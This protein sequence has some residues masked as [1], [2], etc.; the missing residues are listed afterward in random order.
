M[1]Y[2]IREM[3]QKKRCSLAETDYA[4]SISEMLDFR[5]FSGDFYQMR[6]KKLLFK[7]CVTVMDYEQVIAAFPPFESVQYKSCWKLPY[8]TNQLEQFANMCK[9]KEPVAVEGG[10]CLF[11][12]N[13]VLITVLLK[14]GEEQFFDFA[15]GKS[16]RA[17]APIVKLSDYL[18]QKGEQVE[19]LTFQQIKTG[20]T[21][22]EYMNLRYPFEIAKAAGASLVIPIPDMSYRK[23]LMAVLEYIPQA[24]REQALADFDAISEKIKSYYLESI[25]ALQ[26]QFQIPQFCCVHG[27]SEKELAIWY[28]KRTPYIEKKRILRTNKSEMLESI[29]DYISM[30]ALPY[31]LWNIPNILEV[32]TVEETD[33]FHKCKQAHKGIIKMSGIFYPELL[34]HDNAHTFYETFHQWKAY[35]NY[36]E[37]TRN[38]CKRS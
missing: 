35:G 1:E 29:K 18:Y 11:G 19:K 20:L 16:R 34:S 26:K 8:F 13:E 24:V 3:I 4:D 33:P 6:G 28:E 37:L 31:Y 14:N 9:Q 5:L 15:K 30:P 38:Y 7:D 36:D 12:A 10:P 2:T 25:D 22:Q 32:N 27:E 23:Y 17:D 21:P